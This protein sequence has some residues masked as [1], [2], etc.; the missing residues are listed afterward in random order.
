M[1]YRV[2]LDYHHEREL[3]V[4]N[5]SDSNAL[6]LVASDDPFSYCWCIT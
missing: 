5:K 4:G 6:S 3:E 1:K 2:K